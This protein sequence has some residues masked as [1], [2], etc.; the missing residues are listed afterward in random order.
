MTLTWDAVLDV[1]KKGS[2]SGVTNRQIAQSLELSESDIQKVSNLTLIMFE[3]GV[4]RR[5]NNA[6]PM[7]GPLRYFV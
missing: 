1:V 5:Q 7:I 4:V 6:A 3:A 2:P